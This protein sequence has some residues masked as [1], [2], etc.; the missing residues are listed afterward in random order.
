MLLQ[1]RTNHHLVEILNAQELFDPFH[2][3]VAGRY[4]IGEDLPEPERF[5]KHDLVFPSGEALPRCWRDPDYRAE[6]RQHP[7]AR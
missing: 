4:N 5:A 2:D 6:V 3:H 7:H 1:D